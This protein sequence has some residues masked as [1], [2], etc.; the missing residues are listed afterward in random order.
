MCTD[1]RDIHLNDIQAVSPVNVHNLLKGGDFWIPH[2][3]GWVRL[4]KFPYTG[5][6]GFVAEVDDRTLKTLVLVV[7]RID[8]NPPENRKRKRRWEGRPPQAVF[9]AAVARAS[10]G[11]SSVALRNDVFIF[12]NNLFREGLLLMYDPEFISS[13]PSPTLDEISWFT[14]RQSV[15]QQFLQHCVD[16]LQ[17]AKLQVGDSVKILDGS[18]RNLV[19]EVTDIDNAESATVQ[20]STIRSCVVLPVIT[21]RKTIVIGDDVKVTSGPHK[22]F[23]GWV[24]AIKEHDVQIFNHYMCDEVSTYAFIVP[25]TYTYP[26]FPGCSTVSLC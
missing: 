15:P 1:I 20:L 9:N 14:Q 24:V 3:P 21:L 7:P 17:S 13:E 11:D 22:D 10:Y 5:D 8:Y 19:G 2:T 6:L 16:V 26:H 18:Y 12:K 4:T 25:S 23:T